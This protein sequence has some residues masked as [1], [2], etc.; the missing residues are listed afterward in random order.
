[1]PDIEFDCGID[2]SRITSD[3]LPS[4]VI[5]GGHGNATV[6]Q[7][8]DKLVLKLQHGAYAAVRDWTMSK[9]ARHTAVQPLSLVLFP[10]QPRGMFMPLCQPVTPTTAATDAAG[11]ARRLVHL[12]SELHRIGIVHG[13]IKLSNFLVCPDGLIRLCDFGTARFV[14]DEMDLQAEFSVAW[15]APSQLDQR[16]SRRATTFRDDLYSLGA[17]IWE[18][19]AGRQPFTPEDPSVDLDSEDIRD[20]ILDGE[21][22]DLSLIADREQRELAEALLDE[23]IVDPLLTAA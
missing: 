16:T 3:Q 10:D 21:K 15:T 19:H 1:M 12:V 13:D 11:L 7:W 22:L 14:E 6:Y 17:T 9:A 20:L 18:V 8:N 5:H 23:S 2:V 4:K